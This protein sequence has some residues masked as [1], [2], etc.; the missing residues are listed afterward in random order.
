VKSLDLLVGGM[1]KEPIRTDRFNRRL[2]NWA[3]LHRLRLRAKAGLAN[4]VRQNLLSQILEVA[5]IASTK[6][7]R[8]DRNHPFKLAPHKPAL[9]ECNLRRF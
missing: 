7:M 6:V 3:R 1:E 2:G 4:I 5:Y 8:G 9:Q